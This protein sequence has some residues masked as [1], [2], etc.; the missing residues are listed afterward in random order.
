MGYY[1]CDICC[2]ETDVY[3]GE[4]YNLQGLCVNCKVCKDY[5][6]TLP[7]D[8]RLTIMTVG[9]LRLHEI[10]KLERNIKEKENKNEK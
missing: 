2:K 6:K 8:E 5:I 9:I 4:T 7:K 10:L 1:Y 3:D